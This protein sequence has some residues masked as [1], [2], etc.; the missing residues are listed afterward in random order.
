MFRFNILKQQ[1]RDI[2]EVINTIHE[3]ITQQISDLVV[4]L[5][6]LKEALISLLQ[7]HCS[8]NKDLANQLGVDHS[9]VLL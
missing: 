5:P 4:C 9:M 8:D 7:E 1:E 6:E 3:N 2:E